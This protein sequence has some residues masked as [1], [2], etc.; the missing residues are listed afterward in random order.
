MDKSMRCHGDGKVS[1]ALTK[2]FGLLTL[3]YVQPVLP[4]A[5]SQTWP[6]P[7]PDAPSSHLTYR[8]PHVHVDTPVYR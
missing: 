2:R 3:P 1:S 6:P 7:L 4:P 8:P 5:R